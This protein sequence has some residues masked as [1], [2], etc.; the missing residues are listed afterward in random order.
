MSENRQQPTLVSLINF[1]FGQ[2]V[3]DR[4]VSHFLSSPRSQQ[5]CVN[6]GIPENEL[7]RRPLEFFVD[8]SLKKQSIRSKV[9]ESRRKQLLFEAREERKRLI[10]AQKKKKKSNGTTRRSRTS[11]NIVHRP[12]AR[13]NGRSSRSQSAATSP[14]DDTRSTGT[15]TSMSSRNSLLASSIKK[16]QVEL[17]HLFEQTKIKQQLERRQHQAEEQRQARTRQADQERKRQIKEKKKK[18]AL[19]EARRK[20]KL[21]RQKQEQ[22]AQIEDA[23][24]RQEAWKREM[25]ALE[26]AKKRNMAQARAEAQAEHELRRRLIEEHE[27][28]HNIELDLK[29]KQ[30]ERRAKDREEQQR[31]EQE[32][33]AQQK[34]ARR[35]KERRKLKL[36]KQRHHDQLQRKRKELDKKVRAH[37]E[38][39]AAIDSAKHT[40]AEKQKM[41]LHQRQLRAQLARAKQEEEEALGKAI[42]E[43]KDAEIQSRLEHIRQVQQAQKEA[44]K[45]QVQ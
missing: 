13:G 25:A 27:Q 8:S 1:D 3:A 44:H 38:R 20:I 22:E 39:C 6:L 4:N 43:A 26:R 5:A 15:H 21:A 41:L 35:A 33:L 10:R 9:Y 12:Y 16:H 34:K 32:R 2:V 11:K 18:A 7:L 29:R 19:A 28:Q 42:V 23:E 14:S 40:A 36:A 17:R 45:Q 24:R 37:E 31:E 30:M